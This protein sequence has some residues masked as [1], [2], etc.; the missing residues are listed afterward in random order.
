MGFS[1]TGPSGEELPRDSPPEEEVD[2]VAVGA[3]A[4]AEELVFAVVV[5]AGSEEEVL[6]AGASVSESTG[7]LTVVGSGEGVTEAIDGAAE[8][9][10]L[11]PVS[12]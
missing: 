2:W 3:A 12:E 5:I 11:L 10:A 6:G 4:A 1:V 7:M 9:W 8:E